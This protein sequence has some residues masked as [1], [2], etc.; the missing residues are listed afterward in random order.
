MQRRSHLR[1]VFNETPGIGIYWILWESL[2]Q[3]DG[4]AETSDEYLV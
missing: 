1:L 2:K 3:V 4:L